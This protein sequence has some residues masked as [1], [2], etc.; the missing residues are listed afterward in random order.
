MSRKANETK[1]QCVNNNNNSAIIV[2]SPGYVTY[3][4]YFLKDTYVC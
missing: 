4:F 3:V 1:I 2:I